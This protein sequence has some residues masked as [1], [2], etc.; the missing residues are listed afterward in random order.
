LATFSTIYSQTELDWELKVGGSRDDNPTDII[1]AHDGN[2]IVF[3]SPKSID[4]DF[5]TE[6]KKSDMWLLKLDSKSGEIIW[7]RNYG[8]NLNDYAKKVMRTSDGGY[9]LAGHTSSV[10][11]DITQRI[12]RSYKSDIWII[13]IASNG[14]KIWDRCYG[15]NNTESLSSITQTKD[16]GFIISAQTLSRDGAG[17]IEKRPN[18]Y[19]GADI[20]IFK[21]NKEG[22][23]QWQKIFLE[24]KSVEIIE[25]LGNYYV[26]GYTDHINEDTLRYKS[27]YDFW[28][29]M[30][31]LDGN[32]K[33][34][35]N[36]PLGYKE[37]GVSI[38][39]SNQNNGVVILGN[40]YVYDEGDEYYQK[41]KS[42]GGRYRPPELN[43][44]IGAIEID[45][46]GNKVWQYISEESDVSLD[47]Q[48][49]INS[50]TGNY[51]ILANGSKSDST[52]IQITELNL[53]GKEK[54]SININS[55]TPSKGFNI[56]EETKSKYVVAGSKM[57]QSSEDY[58][59]FKLP[60]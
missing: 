58:W 48:E 8:G 46:M 41:V 49:I 5:K 53:N 26:A 60:L 43:N 19:S 34:K 27:K 35:K 29:I 54:H 24:G 14:D 3:G 42:E 4:K 38:T 56:L 47:A 23:I 36:F 39:S 15:G 45:S 31:D 55:N 51:I 6:R 52:F 50:R 7:K 1:K 44:R 25:S 20:W 11:G 21:I 28:V 17:D 59:I 13:K 18:K 22:N 33:W 30:L 2:L 16:D 37:K 10:G 9:L 57:I 12:D 40:L 32:V